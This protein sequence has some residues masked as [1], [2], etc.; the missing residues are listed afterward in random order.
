[1]RWTKAVGI[2]HL[3]VIIC[4][5]P[6]Q[7]GCADSLWDSSNPQVTLTWD[8]PFAKQ[9]YRTW[10][11]KELVVGTPILYTYVKWFWCFEWLL[12]FFD[13]TNYHTFEKFKRS[14]LEVLGHQHFIHFGWWVSL[15][16]CKFRVSSSSKRHH[17]LPVSRILWDLYIPNKFYDLR[18]WGGLECNTIYPTHQNGS[19]KNSSISEKIEKHTPPLSEP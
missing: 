3:I 19:V 14:T 12:S 16:F 5:C 10:T 8:E 15:L 11:W 2:K 9:M 1:M 6:C 13:Q 4:F 18:L 7:H 17:A